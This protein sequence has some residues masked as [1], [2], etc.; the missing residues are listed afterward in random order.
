MDT[1]KSISYQRIHTRIRTSRLPII[2]SV[3]GSIV[4]EAAVLLP[5]IM[6]LFVFFVYLIQAAVISTALQSAATQTV[7]QVAAHMYPVSL[8]AMKFQSDD[9]SG[10]VGSAMSKPP[11]QWMRLTVEQFT[12]EFAKTLPS[13]A[14]DWIVDAGKWAGGAAES[15][16]EQA[17]AAAGQY[18]FQPLLDRYGV[19]QVLQSDRIRLT[20]LKLPDLIEKRDPYI[21]LQVEYDLPMRVPLLMTTITLTAR[22]SERVWV[23]DGPAASGNDG[24]TVTEKPPLEIIS[25]EPKPLKPWGKARLV[26]KG[27]PNEMLKLKVYYK[28]GES[29]AQGLVWKMTDSEGFVSWEWV[30][31][32]HTT[33]GLWRLEV[34][35]EDGRSVDRHFMVGDG[36][37]AHS[38]DDYKR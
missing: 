34:I 14:S 33:E 1:M 25:I 17:Q 23:G 13:P 18:V 5:L 38:D 4:L 9:P 30:V 20:H 8:A 7:R 37:G 29:V 24:G 3:E 35:A 15:A 22:A 28:S 27:A 36:V 2:R 10:T 16:G 12:Q 31:S 21:A 26:A 11:A 6:L 32:G 19:K